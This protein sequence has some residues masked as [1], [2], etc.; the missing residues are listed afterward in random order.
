MRE[1]KLLR[2]G[3]RKKWTDGSNADGVMNIIQAWREKERDGVDQCMKKWRN[4]IRW[5]RNSFGDW[6]EV[7]KGY[8]R[9]CYPGSAFHQKLRRREWETET[10]EI[11]TA[12]TSSPT[13]NERLWSKARRL[14]AFLPWLSFPSFNSDFQN[15]IFLSLPSVRNPFYTGEDFVHRSRT[16]LSLNLVSY[17]SPTPIDSLHVLEPSPQPMPNPTSHSERF[18]LPHRTSSSITSGP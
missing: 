11:F 17:T 4:R 18:V 13:S 7:C 5:N 15:W 16:S 2:R 3:A 10:H 12:K 9:R 1:Y 14:R 6:N 8:V